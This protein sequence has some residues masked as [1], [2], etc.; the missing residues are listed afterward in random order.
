VALA[1]YTQIDASE[2]AVFSP[3]VMRLLRSGL[4]FGG[5]IISDDL[6]DAA[7][8]ASVPAGQRAISFLNA[9]GDMI[10]SQSLAPAE[11]MAQA[12]LARASASASF[13]AEVG[14]AVERILTAKQAY[15]LLP[16]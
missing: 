9:G 1:T 2:L 6:G 3:T 14:R 12:V 16:C 5:V 7:A 13:R 4:G 8:V 10:T 11:T 15:G